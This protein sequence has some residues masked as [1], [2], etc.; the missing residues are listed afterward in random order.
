MALPREHTALTGL[1]MGTLNTCF[2][3]LAW[4]SRYT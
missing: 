3:M 1:A 4:C 2:F